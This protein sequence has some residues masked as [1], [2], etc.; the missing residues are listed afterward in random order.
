MSKSSVLALANA[1][2]FNLTSLADSATLDGFY[3][4]LMWDATR[5][6][7]STKVELVETTRDDAT[8]AL[9]QGRIYA[10]FYDDVM[11]SEASL[12]DLE[13]VNPQWRDL[14]GRPHTWCQQDQNLNAIRVVPKPDAR[15]VDFSFLFGAPMGH[16]FPARSLGVVIAERRED[17][18][19]WLDVPLALALLG[20]EYERESAHRD[21]AFAKV[22]RELGNDLLEWVLGGG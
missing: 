22:C 10:I 2:A 5:W 4:D 17:L 19:E 18:P 8:Y 1:Y 21:V 13:S 3:S 12:Q 9:E 7:I 16:D 15:S 14:V 20:R 6:G 11:L